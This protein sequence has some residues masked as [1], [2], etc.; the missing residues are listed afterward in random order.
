MLTDPVG[1]ARQI[2]TVSIST[3]RGKSSDDQTCILK[4]G[5][6]EFIKD[7]SFVAYWSCRH[8]CTE[9]G[10]LRGINNNVFVP[11]EPMKED[12]FARVIDGLSKSPRTKPY[13]VN[14]IKN[15][16]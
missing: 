10:I 7:P 5:D 6:H 4:P 1:P 9:D 8:D 3:I 13:A 14:F 12:I 16:N 15:S 11:M 2:L